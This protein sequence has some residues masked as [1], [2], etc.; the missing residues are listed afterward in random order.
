MCLSF[1]PANTPVYKYISAAPVSA[2][3]AFSID[4]YQTFIPWSM[5]VGLMQI[6][7]PLLP[8]LQ[9]FRLVMTKINYMYTTTC[10]CTLIVNVSVIIEPFHHYSR[11]GNL[12]TLILIPT[13]PKP[14]VFPPGDFKIKRTH[15]CVRHGERLRNAHVSIF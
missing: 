9:I 3:R 13:L 1:L 6:C 14:T 4:A 15:A 12:S 8:S 10:A 5:N 2:K 7:T 11:N